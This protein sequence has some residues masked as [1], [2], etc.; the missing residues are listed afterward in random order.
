[1][2]HSFLLAVVLVGLCLPARAQAQ[3]P[4]GG[5]PAPEQPWGAPAPAAPAAPAQGMWGDPS[6]PPA[7][8]NGGRWVHVQMH[9]D[10]PRTRIDKVMGPGA[11]IPVCFSPCDKMLDTSSTYIIQGEGIRAT[12]RFMLPDDRDSVRLD[13]QSGSTS[14]VAGGAVL[15]GAGLITAYA[16]LFVLA[17]TAVSNTASDLGTTTGQP[18]HHSPVLGEVM[19]L[20]GLAAGVVGLYLVAST[21]TTVSSSSGATFT[22]D[23]GAPRKWPRLALTPNGLVF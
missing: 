4:P 2:A 5:Q 11:S 22:R 21:H 15:M 7:P 23:T 19:I 6:A 10:D 9:S 8:G 13:V 14:R 20:G 3:Q 16:G 1:L 18:Q 12:S 17:A